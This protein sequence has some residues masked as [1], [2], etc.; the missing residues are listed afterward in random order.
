[1]MTMSTKWQ[2]CPFFRLVLHEF[3]VFPIETDT[4]KWTAVTEDSAKWGR[5]DSILGTFYNDSLRAKILKT[6][7]T[8]L[9]E[10]IWVLIE[11]KGFLKVEEA[12]VWF[13]VQNIKRQQS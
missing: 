9:F 7:M 6:L 3:L 13:L 5:S 8:S 10:D 2:L 1:M 12:I 4:K 11:N